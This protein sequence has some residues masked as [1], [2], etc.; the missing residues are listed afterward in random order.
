MSTKGCAIL[1]QFFSCFPPCLEFDFDFFADFSGQ[2]FSGEHDSEQEDQPG[3]RIG[4]GSQKQE[5]M[6]I[7]D[8]MQ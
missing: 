1:S 4:N 6:F 5:K 3:S 2:V 7:R 8:G